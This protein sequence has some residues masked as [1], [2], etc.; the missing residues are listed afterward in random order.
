MLVVNIFSSIYVLRFIYSRFIWTYSILVKLSGDVEENPRPKRKPC[1]SF[2]ICHWNVN[3]L[4]DQNFSKVSLLTAY[5]S[6][7]KFDVI[8]ISETFLN[9]DTAFDDDNLKIEGYNIVRSD[10]PS[11]SRQGGVCIYYNQSLALKISDIKYLQECIVF[12]VLIA[13]KLSNFISLY[14]SPSQTT[15]IFDQ[16]S[17]NVQLS[18]DEVANHNPFLTVVLG[19]F[20]VKLE[21][22]YK[23]DKTSYEGAEIDALL[24]QFGLH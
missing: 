20:N 17:D 19:N 13:N 1:Q 5:I 4:S 18:L 9:S 7:H 3:S 6:I 23:H 14:Q 15:D 22:W 16:F 11:N 2:S 8:C 24:T 10:H 12:Q 21:N